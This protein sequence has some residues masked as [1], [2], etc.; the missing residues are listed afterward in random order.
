MSTRRPHSASAIGTAPLV[1]ICAALVLVAAPLAGKFAGWVSGLFLVAIAARLVMNHRSQRM[2]SLPAKLVVIA[3]SGAGLMATYGSLLGVEPLLSILLILVSL[4]LLETNGVRDFQVLALLGFFLALCGL[5]FSQELL[6]WLYVAGVFIVLTA[7]LVGF[8][9]G[10]GAAALRPSARL[11]A[12]MLAQALP[13]VAL[14]F[15]FFPRTYG[16]FRFQFGRS[17]LNAAGMSDRLSPGSVSS[18]VLSDAIA[19]RADFPD[20]TTPSTADMYWRGGVLW[21]G[22]GLTWVAGPALTMERRLG[23]L[24]GPSFRQRISLQPHGTNWLFALDRP[25]ANVRGA[26]FRP[27]GF[28]QSQRPVFN[29]LHYEVVSRPENR[30]LT[31]APDQREAALAVAGRIS[32]EVQALVGK[33]TA[34][35]AGGRAVVDAALRHFGAEAFSYTLQPGTYGEDA[36]DEFLFQRRAGFCEHYAAAFATLM[37]VAGIPSRIVIGYH[38][39]DFN[40]LGQYVIVRQ[41]H[42]HAWCE[43]W[44][45]ESG[46]VRIDPTKAIAPE[47]I[48]AGLETYFENRANQTAAAAGGGEAR[49]RW[50]NAMQ[51]ARLAWDSI[52]Y[53]WDLHVQNFDEE[54]QRTFLAMI[55]FGRFAWPAILTWS[56]LAIAVVLGILG[57]WLRRSVR[58]RGDETAR[59][60]A[61]FCRVLSAAGVDRE[62][63]EGPV[64]FAARAALAF[65]EHAAALRALGAQYAALRYAPAPPPLA[66]FLAAIRALPHLRRTATPASMPRLSAPAR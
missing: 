46:W 8:H 32:P 14:L 22:E 41:A 50:R 38:G 57:L 39:G 23:Q 6:A 26:I 12:V 40:K 5:F 29:T 45:R 37:R 4:K 54:N 13:I 35:G 55:G 44:L 51:E 60:Y 62:P 10:T 36:L 59:A 24:A 15:L 56:A 19:F 43:V 33:W 28:L 53:H 65:P 27:G 21:R 61:R 58:V 25:A 47:R 64:H 63:W 16:G 66:P 34:S 1:G 7:T 30:E 49:A 52:N 31:L 2:P 9:R 18:L 20:G 11:A 17:I 48:G 42:A 3:L